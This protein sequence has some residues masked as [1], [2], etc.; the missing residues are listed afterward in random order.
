[1]IEIISIALNLILGSSLIL[2]YSSNRR[3]QAAEASSAEIGV[4]RGEFDINRQQIEFLGHQLSQ[5]YSEIDKMQE[6]INE[7]RSQIIELI[8]QTK[9]LEVSL[10]NEACIRRQQ[11]CLREGCT[12]R[13]GVGRIDE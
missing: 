9:Q 4:R 13:E 8:R 1:M 7:K 11:A 10:I 3:K 5:A 12:E 6:I 2:F